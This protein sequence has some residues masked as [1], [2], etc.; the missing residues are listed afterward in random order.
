HP[1]EMITAQQGEIVQISHL[2]FT[3]KAQG[4]KT[5]LTQFYLL[6]KKSNL[7]KW[8]LHVPPLHVPQPT[9]FWELRPPVSVETNGESKNEKK[10]QN[11]PKNQNLS[12]NC[13]AV[14]AHR[15]V[16]RRQSN[17]LYQCPLCH[18]RGRFAN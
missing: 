8:R 2:P 14:S 13:S 17:F 7:R 6:T 15:S 5:F 11:H 18:G 9:E 1:K 16:L 4:G 12:D 3:R 10:N